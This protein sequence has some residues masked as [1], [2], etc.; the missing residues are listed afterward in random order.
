MAEEI[1][2]QAANLA[3]GTDGEAG[4]PTGTGKASGEPKAAQEKGGQPDTGTELLY[5]GKTGAQLNESYKE[6]QRQFGKNSEEMKA[7][8]GQ[9]ERMG[10]LEQVGKWFDYLSNNPRFADFMQQEQSR[11]AFGINMDELDD[12]GRKALAL[13]TKVAETIA[14]QKVKTALQSQVAPLS[15]TVKAQAIAEHF[16]VMDERYPEWRE[17]QDDMAEL[18]EDLPASKQNSPTMEDIED[19]Y[20]KAVRKAGKMGDVAARIHQKKLEDKK[21]KSTE[22]PAS[23]TQKGEPPKPK[24]IEEA[25][26]IAKE[27]MSG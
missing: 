10:G 7:I 27:Q 24:S 4:E 15:E 12:D 5:D 17:F 1:A 21:A 26:R 11:N 20:W 13:V 22:K 16:A 3:Q 2:G 9:L 19:L 8:R 14:D 18:A 23:S 25:F 6:L